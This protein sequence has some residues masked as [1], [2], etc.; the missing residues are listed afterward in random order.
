MCC[1]GTA[2]YSLVGLVVHKQPLLHREGMSA[3]VNTTI[4]KLSIVPDHTV[5]LGSLCD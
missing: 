1:H 5:L 4:Q 3:T 2:M